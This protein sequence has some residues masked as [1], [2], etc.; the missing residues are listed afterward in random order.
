MGTRSNII[1]HRADGKWSSIYCHWDGYPSHHGPI[2]TKNYATQTKAESLVSHGDLSS[3]APKNS[4]PKGHSLDK[5][6]PGYCIY[7]GRDRG[8]EGVDAQ[9]CD[10][11]RDVW[12]DCW[13]E[14]VYI[15]QYDDNDPATGK[16]WFTSPEAGVEAAV[17]LDQDVIDGKIKINASVKAFSAVLFHSM[18]KVI[19]SW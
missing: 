1:V 2:L 12:P 14:F 16:W 19:D 5:P 13:T 17:P 11:L 15:W 8:E 6:K 4:K 7:Y 18:H 10:T 3:L 9:V